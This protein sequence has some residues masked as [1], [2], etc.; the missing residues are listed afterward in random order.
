MVLP[1]GKN[2]TLIR[3]PVAA[4]FPTRARGAGEG[5]GVCAYN[6]VHGL[7]LQTG[8]FSSAR[9][10]S[11][12]R[13]DISTAVTVMQMGSPRRKM[14]LRRSPMSMWLFSMKV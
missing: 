7:G 2:Q 6:D 9:A 5:L 12:R 3:L 14:R 4:T 8:Y 13:V 10:N 1:V 11:T